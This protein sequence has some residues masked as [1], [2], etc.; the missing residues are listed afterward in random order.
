MDEGK[1]Q[2]IIL[3]CISNVYAAIFFPILFFAYNFV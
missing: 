3:I 2:Y 1:A